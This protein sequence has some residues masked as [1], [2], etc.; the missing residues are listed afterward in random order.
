LTIKRRFLDGYEAFA[1]DFF[2]NPVETNRP[3]EVFHWL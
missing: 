2:S 3:P 1:K